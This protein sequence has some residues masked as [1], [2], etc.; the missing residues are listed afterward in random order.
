MGKKSSTLTSEQTQAQVDGGGVQRVHRSVQFDADWFLGI[1]FPCTHNQAHGQ[2][3][4]DAPVP[5]VQRIRERRARRCSGEAHVKQL[6]MIGAQANLDVAQGLAPSQLREGH[7]AKQI[8]AAQ[9]AHARI[10]SVAFDDASKGLPWHVLH[11]LRKQ[12]L[13]HIHASPQVV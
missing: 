5:M 8:G 4:I 12:R 10:A 3:V 13:A 9:S 6:G 1:E 11:D 7:H 2:S